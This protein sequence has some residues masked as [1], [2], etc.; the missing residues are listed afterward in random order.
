M[1]PHARPRASLVPI[2][3]VA[4]YDS[5]IAPPITATGGTVEDPDQE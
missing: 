5:D 2:T 3:K 4:G 1:K